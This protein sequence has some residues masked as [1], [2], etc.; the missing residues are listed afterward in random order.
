[1][2]GKNT[3]AYFPKTSCDEEKKMA[4]KTRVNI[5]KHFL[6]PRFSSRISLSVL[7]SKFYS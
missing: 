6:S 4:F 5:L 1:M 3:L 7:L 2:S